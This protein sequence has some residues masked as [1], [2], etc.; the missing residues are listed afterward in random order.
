[1][2]KLTALRTD[3]GNSIA[4]T[5]AVAQSTDCT[6]GCSG[7]SSEVCGGPSR[8]S[9]FWNGKTPPAGPST[10]P[11][12][13]GYGFYGCYTYVVPRWQASRVAAGCMNT[14]LT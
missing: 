8:L 4:S 14:G 2:E 10:N 7:N 13:L 9:V 5:G 6:M 11:G 12:T 3:C 1:M